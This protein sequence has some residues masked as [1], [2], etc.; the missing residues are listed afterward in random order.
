MATKLGTLRSAA[1]KRAT[2]VAVASMSL[3]TSYATLGDT[4]GY[5]VADNARLTVQLSWTT[6]TG[7]QV[8]IAPQVSHDGVTWAPAPLFGVPSS[9]Q[10]TVY[11][12]ESIFPAAEWAS[13]G[14]AVLALDVQV[15][16]WRFVRFRA[17]ADAADGTLS[18]TIVAGML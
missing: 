1:D 17:K 5:E 9:G 6:G 10:V 13:G 12:A 14:S 7:T 18:G 16:G 15:P 4:D 8:T 2:A 3:G 11:Q